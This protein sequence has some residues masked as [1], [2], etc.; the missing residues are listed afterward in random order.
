MSDTYI[1]YNPNTMTIEQYNT[2]S[3]EL[4]DIIEM[5][6]IVVQSI[7]NKYKINAMCSCGCLIN[8]KFIREFLNENILCASC[9][10]L[11]HGME[12][13]REFAAKRNGECLSV[14][15]YTGSKSYYL[16]KCN[17][18]G[19]DWKATW[20]SINHRNS[21]CST[22]S[23]STSEN[24]CRHALEEIT[25]YKFP[26]ISNF[27]KTDSTRG[28]EIDCYNEELKVGVEYDGIQHLKYVPHFHGAS[29]SGK[30]EAQQY[31]D[32]NK[33]NICKQMGITL[34]RV[35]YTTPRNELRTHI[36]A[37]IRGLDLP[38]ELVDPSKFI[39]D[40]E[41]NNN[42]SKICSEKSSEYIKQ[43]MT[44]VNKKKAILH[45]T[46][47]DSWKS[48][49]EITCSK[50]HNF[51]TNLDR[52]F[53]NPPRWCPDCA[54]NRP[55]KKENI[56]AILEPK[57]FILTNMV[58]RL[59]KSY[60][61]R[62]YISYICDKYHTVTVMWDNHSGPNDR[63]PDCVAEDTIDRID[64]NA[65]L[66]EANRKLSIKEIAHKEVLEMG[67]LMG[68]YNNSGK[69]LT[70]FRCIAHNHIFY[71][72]PKNFTRP[73]NKNKEF[74]TQCILQNDFPNLKTVYSYIH[75]NKPDQ[76]F[77]TTCIGCGDT[78]MSTNK[79][80][81][82]RSQCCTNRICKYS[83]NGKNYNIQRSSTNK[84][85]NIPRTLE[86]MDRI[87]NEAI[88]QKEIIKNDK[89][90]KKNQEKY[91]KYQN[92]PRYIIPV[93]SSKSN[94]IELECRLYGHKFKSKINIID[95][96]S[97]LEF[98]AQCILKNDYPHH[99][100]SEPFDF[101]D[102]KLE[103]KQLHL[104]CKCGKKTDLQHKLLRKSTKLCS[105]KCPYYTN[106]RDIYKYNNIQ[107]AAI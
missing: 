10:Q 90:Y 15:N 38:I 50:N 5:Y 78:H 100:L 74:C 29:D 25:G 93:F 103:S 19:N 80:I 53:H 59:D 63:C 88:K 4:R 101:M 37:L 85:Q 11:E 35:D 106:S 82:E 87:I 89:Q 18:C 83:S 21:W 72:L 34:L 16:W 52:L 43:I 28:F 1:P 36:H 62:L 22:C 46:S 12:V 84:Y 75:F 99:Q 45:S 64:A 32:E 26:K 107:T 17:N 30:F 76:E 73:T 71:N 7:I 27:S 98:C 81:S 95:N 104:I 49:I 77:R 41:F 68:E 70:E 60:R 102:N 40:I 39:S 14:G 44:I 79:S 97:D 13:L 42:V 48:P 8:T 86:D 2:L 67:Y 20:Y 55:L 56:L 24:I 6:E 3:L 66:R 58:Y 92:H 51:T 9:S 33:T 61:N 94:P 57:G 91:A 23:G 96:A 54:H 31:R 65:Y 47:C 69:N 105:D